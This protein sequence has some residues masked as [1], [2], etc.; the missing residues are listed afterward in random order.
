[1]NVSAPH[2]PAVG[3]GAGPPGRINV[4]LCKQSHQ[5]SESGF[6]DPLRLPGAGATSGMRTGGFGFHTDVERSPWWIVDLAS[7][8]AIDEIVVHNRLDAGSERLRTLSILVSMDIEGP[9]LEVLPPLIDPPDEMLQQPIQVPFSPPVLARFVRVQLNELTYLHL[10]EMEVFGRPAPLDGAAF[11]T[12]QPTDQCAGRADPAAD[13]QG[14]WRLNRFRTHHRLSSIVPP[15]WAGSLAIDGPPI[16]A[17][18]P[19]IRTIRV[20]PYER[21]GNNFYQILNACIL[22]RR[23]GV[24]SLQLSGF[25]SDLFSLPF[26]ADGICV[27]GHGEDAADGLTMTGEFYFPKGLEPLVGDYSAAFLAE[28]VDRFMRPLLTRL[29]GPS[30]SLG[31]R[32]LVMHFRGGDLFAGSGWVHSWY[33]QPPASHYIRALKHA[34]THS[35]VTHVHLVFEDRGN[36]AIEVVQRHLE[37][38]DIAFSLQSASFHEDATSLISAHHLVVGYGTFCEA[39]GAMSSRLQSYYAFRQFSSQRLIGFWAQARLEDLLRARGVRTYAIDDPDVSYIAPETWSNSDA[40]NELIRQYPI[41][42]L[43]LMERF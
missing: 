21:F 43:R 15:E 29:T 30:G 12:G 3:I 11:A 8:H 5:S 14:I 28:T 10:D 40:Q 26:E 33:V 13:W 34:Q 36:P 1:M 42:R 27:M 22:A 19:R 2:G 31:E 41:H 7:A 35:G 4:A 6:L 24:R 17:Q 23:L 38:H 32:T 16:D 18:E 9:W 37:H 39:L 25:R 20:R